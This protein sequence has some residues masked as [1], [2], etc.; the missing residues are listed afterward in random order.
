MDF[1]TLLSPNNVATGLD[2]KNQEE[3]FSTAASLFETN[4]GLSRKTILNGLAEREKLGSTALGHAVAIPHARIK[5]LPV[6]AGA[7]IKLRY[8]IEFAAPDK[9]AVQLFFILLVPSGASEL[10]L[11]ILSELAQRF[12]DRQVRRSLLATDDGL[13]LYQRFIGAT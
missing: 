4:N 8:P 10:H 13:E 7:L 3:V 6:S 1:S 2:A 11:Q 9:L 5:G 12:S